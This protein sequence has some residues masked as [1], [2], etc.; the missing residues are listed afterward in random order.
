ML[1]LMQLKRE[2]IGIY[3]KG[4][5]LACVIINPDGLCDTWHLR[6]R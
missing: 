6:S 3:E 1:G 2:T 5:A 4:K